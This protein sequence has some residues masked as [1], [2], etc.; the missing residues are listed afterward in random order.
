[1]T[2]YS[3]SD[4]LAPNNQSGDG[5]EGSIKWSVKVDIVPRNWDEDKDK[6]DFFI[7][8][9]LST[10]NLMGLPGIDE[11]KKICQAMAI[12][13]VIL[14]PDDPYLNKYH[15]YN[16]KWAPGEEMASMDDGEGDTFFLLFTVHG[17]IMLGFA[18][19][20]EMTPYKHGKLWPGLI[21]KVPTEFQPALQEVA[22]SPE[23][24]TFCIWRAHSD[25]TWQRGDIQFPFRD[26]DKTGLISRSSPPGYYDYL[27]GSGEMLFVFDSKP[28]TYV[29]W[30]NDYFYDGPDFIGRVMPL[31]IV[32]RIFSHEPLTNELVKALNPECN[33]MMISKEV[34]EIGYPVA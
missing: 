6:F 17:A 3:D 31:E 21:E 11:F 13:E 1:M 28:E 7:E 19:E 20:S 22:F 16:S 34:E 10:R 25:G 15:Y 9:A 29:Q 12:I 2:T 5:S 32:K 30:A 27:D 14:I 18:H 26:G 33:L 23:D 4:N 8:P 24:L